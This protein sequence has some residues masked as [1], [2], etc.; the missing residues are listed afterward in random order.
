MVIIYGSKLYG[1][2]D[3]VPGLFHVETKFG[4]LY[5]I[6]LIPVG[7]FL[8]LNKNNGGFNGVPI[9]MSAKSILYAWGRTLTFVGGLIASIIAIAAAQKGTSEWVTPAIVGAS[10]LGSF[11]ILAFHKGSTRAS[12]QRACQLGDYVGLTDQGKAILDQI[13]LPNEEADP[14]ANPSS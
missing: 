6:P 9:P 4:H 7:S 1:K 2:V 3:V 12:Y 10:A 14:F 8:V 13:Y 11:L 5:Y